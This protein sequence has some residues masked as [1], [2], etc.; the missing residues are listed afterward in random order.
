MDFRLGNLGNSGP[1]KEIRTLYSNGSLLIRK[2]E[3]YKHITGLTF[4][5]DKEGDPIQRTRFYGNYALHISLTSNTCLSSGVSFGLVNYS[6]KGSTGYST[7]SD[8][9][10]DGN[11]GVWVYSDNYHI[12]ISVNQIFNRKLIPINEVFILAPYLSITGNR[13]IRIDKNLSLNPHLLLNCF[14]KNYS[15]LDLAML[16]T[17]G[18]FLSIGSSYRSGRGIAWIAGISNIPFM[19]NNIELYFC[20]SSPSFISKRFN[21]NS[22]QLSL[23]YL[24]KKEKAKE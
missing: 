24:F 12:G 2:K 22:Y 15:Q 21:V 7:G 20:Y 23:N 19:K 9:N 18:D 11:A 1:F 13:K 6:F 10:Y 4:Y 14:N 5:N 3:Q 16:A 8:I 17:I